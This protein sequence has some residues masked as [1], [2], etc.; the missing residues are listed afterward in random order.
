[1]ARSNRA[2]PPALLLL[3]PAL[4]LPCGVAAL[5]NGAARRPPMGY[6]TWYDLGGGDNLNESAIRATA[7]AMVSKNL[8]AAGYRWL[9]LDDGFI[10]PKPKPK[11]N[12]TT[13]GAEPDGESLPDPG[14]R[15][16]NGSLAENRAKFPSGMGA[17]SAYLGSRGL[18]LG[19][20]TARGR[21]TCCGLAGSLNHEREDARRL[22]IDWNASYIKMDSCHGTPPDPRGSPPG[23]AAIAQYRNFSQALNATVRYTPRPHGLFLFVCNFP[24][25]FFLTL[26]RAGHGKLSFIYERFK[27]CSAPVCCRGGAWCSTP[28]GTRAGHPR[29]ASRPAPRSSSTS[30]PPLQ[31]RGAKN[32]MGPVFFPVAMVS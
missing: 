28:A 30:A 27:R 22:A 11:D 21:L 18:A 23:T 20:Y 16:P 29:A 3:L 25:R 6:N 12:N 15:L 10:A 7:D 26:S 17:L 8:L 9:N 13:L 19:L 32:T 5:D 1:M 2:L 4:L 24:M 31:T 14:G